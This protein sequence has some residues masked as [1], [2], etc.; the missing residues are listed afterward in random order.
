MGVG[1]RLYDSGL[2]YRVKGEGLRVQGAGF[3]V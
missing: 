3:K 2:G 1:F